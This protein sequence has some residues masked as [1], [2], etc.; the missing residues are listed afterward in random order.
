MR[1]T[2]TFLWSSISLTSLRAS[3]TGWTCVLK[4]R[5]KT[6]SKRPSI[7]CSIVRSTDN[8]EGFPLP[9]SLMRG[10]GTPAVQSHEGHGGDRGG[11]R[12]REPV[13]TRRERDR[14]GEQGG[15]EDG[16]AAQ[17]E[18]ARVGQDDR[19]DDEDGG[20]QQQDVVAAELAQQ[21]PGD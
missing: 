21:R 3:S 6:P 10:P 8:A 18:A 7:F 17:A 2:E 1:D 20:L 19:G 9:P 15:A 4:A 11:A 5:P 16:D 12:E 14:G 13:Q